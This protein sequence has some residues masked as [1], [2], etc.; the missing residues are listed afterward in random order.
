[1]K[2]RNNCNLRQCFLC[3]HCLPAWLPAVAGHRKVQHFA[4]GETVFGEGDA[5]TGMY[6]V[7]EEI[8]RA[9]V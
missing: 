9:H 7:Y 6:F 8:G 5:V 1:M 4:K 3:R 2:V